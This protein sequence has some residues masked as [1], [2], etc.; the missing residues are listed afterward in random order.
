M[1]QGRIAVCLPSYF[2][3]SFIHMQIRTYASIVAQT[4][5][6]KRIDRLPPKAGASSDSFAVYEEEGPTL[7]C[8]LCE[9][10]PVE[11]GL[12]CTL[13]VIGIASLFVYRQS[14]LD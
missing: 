10:E 5:P 13:G 14:S 11:D 1:L 8:P 7:E 9:I 12:C 6:I 2:R 3:L 4:C